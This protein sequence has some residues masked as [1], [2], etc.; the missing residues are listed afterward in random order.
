MFSVFTMQGLLSLTLHITCEV[1]FLKNLNTAL[2]L[3]K[4]VVLHVR[5]SLD[6]GTIS[7]SVVEA[8]SVG[9]LGIAGEQ[10]EIK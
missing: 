10:K 1:P 5:E 7:V 2:F 8:V 4:L 6:E 3:T 9:L